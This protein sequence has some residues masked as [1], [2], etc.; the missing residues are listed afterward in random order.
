MC[1]VCI[2][3]CTGRIRQWSAACAFVWWRQWWYACACVRSHVTCCRAAAGLPPPPPPL[4]GGNDVYTP[5]SAA[6]FGACVRV[7]VCLWRAYDDVYGV[8]GSP[9]QSPQQDSKNARM[10]HTHTRARSHT[11]VIIKM[12]TAMTIILVAMTLAAVAAVA[13]SCSIRYR[14]FRKVA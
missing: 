8:T 5:A 10:S 1:V 3:V 13:I 11:V 12:V 14:D 7:C 9:M 4:Y 2:S 6:G